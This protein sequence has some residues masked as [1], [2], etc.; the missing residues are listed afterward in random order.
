M[1][2]ERLIYVPV[3]ILANKQDKKDAI[4]D[5]QVSEVNFI[6]KKLNLKLLKLEEHKERK[7]LVVKTCFGGEFENQ[8]GFEQVLNW[9]SE[10]LSNDPSAVQRH[11]WR[12]S[13][14]LQT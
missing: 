4:T 11:E 10:V 2:D 14:K 12:K 9:L 3:C 13:Q 7:F 5:S 1:K 6:P 8:F